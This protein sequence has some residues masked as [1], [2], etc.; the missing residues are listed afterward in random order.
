MNISNL[1][2]ESEYKTNLSLDT[3]ITGVTC[4]SRKVEKGFLFVCISGT[5]ADGH[6]FAQKA[7]EMGAGAI[8]CERDLGL[9]NQI[10][11]QDSRKIYALACA[12][13]FGNPAEKLSLIGLTGTNGKTTVTF[14][15]KHILE[16]CGHKTGLIGTI[17]NMVGDRVIET[18]LTT[19]DAWQ[20][21]WLFSE[22]VKAGCEYCVMEVSSHALEQDRVN[23]LKFKTAAFTNLTQDHLDFHGTIENYF[24]AKKKLF[25]MAENAVINADD[26]Y[27]RIIADGFNVNKLSYA[28]ESSADFKA[29]NVKYESDK[30]TF[31]LVYN[32][33]RYDTDIP[34]PGKFSVYNAL[35]ALG[36][37][38]ASG[39]SPKKA[40]IALESATGVKGR[41]EVVPTGRDFTVLIDYAHTPDG[42][43]N[44][45]SAM[46]QIAKGRVVTLVGCG[47]DRDAAKRP[48]M[49]EAAAKLSDFVII[50]SDN[51]R[52]EDP[53]KI[54]EDILPG[55]K[56]Y[57]TPYVVIEERRDAIKYAVENAQK[58]DIIILAGKG[59]E[60]Y[61]ILKTGKIH[62]DEREVLAEILKK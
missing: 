40:A 10:L 56:N 20:M 2:G 44:I 17:E 4:D 5:A 36:A 48:L 7:F 30:V 59:H 19:P 54:I 25:G 58:D 9:E 37:A 46:R 61:Q 11:V 14:L 28:I 55:L 22:M 1:L 12:N 31:S 47:G 45:V 8:I 43:V 15:I 23:N 51:P 62:F 52:S 32:Q 27:G 21:Q 3:E 26:E 35:T 6:Q 39:V 60:T 53:A 41:V 33:N 16:Q 38:I 34:I 24:N 29:E 13:W 49:G 50:T 57:D 18:N 42:I